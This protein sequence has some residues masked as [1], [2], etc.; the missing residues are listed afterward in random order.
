MKGKEKL[1]AATRDYST[2][3][4]VQS[5]PNRTL[6]NWPLLLLR[7]TIMLTKIMQNFVILCAAAEDG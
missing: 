3:K 1:D 4:A 6:K 2:V 5:V 7:I